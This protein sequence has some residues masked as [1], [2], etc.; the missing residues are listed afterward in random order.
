MRGPR[1]AIL[2]VVLG[3]ACIAAGGGVSAVSSAR[4][5]HVAARGRHRRGGTL[6]VLTGSQFR[7]LD[8]GE[9]YDALDYPV[10]YATQ[11]P[12]YSVRPGAGQRLVPDLAAGPPVISDHGR[13]VTVRIRRGV[14]FSPP[15]NREVTSAD[16]AYAIERGGNRHLERPAPYFASYFGLIDGALL[17]DGGRIPGISTPNQ[18]TIVFHL[19]RSEA[20]FFTRALALPLTAPVPVGYARRLDASRPSRYQD[21]EVATGP[22]MIKNNHAGRVL[23]VGYKPGRSLV[24][25]R[26]PNWNP[27]SDYRPAYVNRIVIRI[28]GD[29]D[30]IG[31]RV[32][33]GSGMLELDQPSP[34]VARLAQRLY[35]QQLLIT[36]GVGVG[37]IWVSFQ[38]SVALAVR[39]ALWAALDR[40]AMVQAAGGALA[41]TVANHFIY[42]GVPGFRQAGGA[43]GPRVPYNADPSGNP[44]LAASYMRQAGFP[45]GHADH[46]ATVTVI[47]E[48]GPQAEEAQLVANAFH[49]L[50]Y[51]TQLN[52]SDDPLLQCDKRR[53]FAVCTTTGSSKDFNDAETVLAPFF[54]DYPELVVEDAISRAELVNG[55]AARAR[56]W[57]GV[58]RLLVNQAAAIPWIYSNNWSLRSKDVD[59]VADQ[60]NDGIWDLSFTSLK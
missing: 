7:Y 53:V 33:G 40:S 51:S 28:G 34:S 2:G 37:M 54:A 36:R 38:T 12:L 9:S 21:Y 14:R 48:S 18:F 6:V 55:A 20:S 49:E 30:V 59:A 56:A 22:Y 41:G 25:V 52:L 27:R 15:V 3:A 5:A 31:R 24:L 4:G 50:G 32:L 1:S 45:S 42:P 57:A 8:P 26:N 60:W 47:G 11:R 29:P 44:A 17:A 23:G 13:T 35:R 16:V 58:D 19:V 39:R 46:S 43:A 10:V